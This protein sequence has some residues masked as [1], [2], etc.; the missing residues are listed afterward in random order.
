MQR[1]WRPKRITRRRYAQ[2]REL[3]WRGMIYHSVPRPRSGML[4]N[5]KSNIGVARFLETHSHR[6]TQAIRLSHV[7]AAMKGI[8][9]VGDNRSS[10]GRGRICLLY[11]SDAADE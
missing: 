9:A 1:Q 5:M 11:T 10:R 7:G 3:C 8:D 6:V 2:A 4:P